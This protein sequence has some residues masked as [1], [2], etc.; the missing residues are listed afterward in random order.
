[1]TAFTN[2]PALVPVETPQSVQR[3][4]PSPSG[5]SMAEKIATTAQN[6]DNSSGTINSDTEALEKRTDTMGEQLIILRTF[7]S[8]RSSFPMDLAQSADLRTEISTPRVY[9]R[10]NVSSEGKIPLT[11]DSS[12]KKSRFIQSGN[13]WLCIVPNR[14]NS[15]EKTEMETENG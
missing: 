10:V 2:L 5:V 1:M 8:R 15:K 13:L 11:P 9:D 14:R 7:L 4:I 6:N 12:K 3:K